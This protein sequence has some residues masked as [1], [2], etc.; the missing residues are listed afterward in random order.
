M[1]VVV[2]TVTV[3][4]TAVE[5]V[6]SNVVGTLQV[7]GLA[8]EAGAVVTVQVRLTTPVKLLVGV[9]VIVAVFP[10]VAPAT[11]ESAAACKGKL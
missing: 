7:A 11:S 9:A 3:L 8:A 2:A 10:V 4:V 5:P 1:S 6:I